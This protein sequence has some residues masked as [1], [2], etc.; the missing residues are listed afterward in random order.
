MDG[1][2]IYFRDSS[3]IDL[4]FNTK[5]SNLHILSSNAYK[6]KLSA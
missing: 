2:S 3:S 5:K 4:L 1:Q 6:Y